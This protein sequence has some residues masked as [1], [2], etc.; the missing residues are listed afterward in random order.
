MSRPQPASQHTVRRHNSALVL[1][2]IAEAPGSSRAA[3]AART[4][5]TKATVSSLVDRM[6][7]AGLVAEGEAQAAFADRFQAMVARDKNHPSVIM[8]S[9]GNESWTGRNLERMYRYSHDRDPGRPVHYE[10]CPDGR[11]SDV[12]SRMYASHAEV[13]LIGR[14]EE[15]RRGVVTRLD[16][17]RQLAPRPQRRPLWAGPHPANG[18]H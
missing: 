11:W 15:P 10:H 17:G 2:A 14:H 18:R 13:D 16:D 12:Y 7:G 1:D 8:W 9:L 4:G 3:V 6:I 5:L